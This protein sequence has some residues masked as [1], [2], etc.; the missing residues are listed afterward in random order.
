MLCSTLNLVPWIHSKAASLMLLAFKTASYVMPFSYHY[1]ETRHICDNDNATIAATT[2]AA[3][4]ALP[5]LVT[6][7]LNTVMTQAQ[8][9]TGGN[10]TE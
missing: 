5:R 8:N 6:G 4:A 3:V 9:I 7:S 10:T 1:H 2:A